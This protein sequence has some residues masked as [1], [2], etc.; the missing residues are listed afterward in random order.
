ME[1][2]AFMLFHTRPGMGEAEAFE[3]SFAYIDMAEVLGL[4]VVWLAEYHFNPSRSVLSCPPVTAA[5]IAGRTKRL[6]VGMAVRVLPLGNPLRIAE[7]I[8]TLDHVLKGRF[9]FGVGRSGFL[10]VYEGFNIPYEESRERLYEYLDVILK[11]WTN[12]RF[13]YRGKH[14]SCD[15]VCVV[16]KPYQSPHPRLRIATS[17]PETFAALGSKGIPIFA[18]LQSKGLG[19]GAEGVCMYRRAWDEAGHQGEPSVF[20]RVPVY[21][22]DTKEAALKEPEESMM[23]QLRRLGNQLIRSAY[24]EGGNPDYHSL[25]RGERLMGLPWERVAREQV[26]VD[27][28]HEIREALQLTG[29]VG[30]F[31]AGE[32]IPPDKVARSLRLFCE[33]VVPAFK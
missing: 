5:A 19:E 14:F 13:S 20:L 27:R 2:G 17:T 6:K 11:A 29:V 3:E 1:F 16:P 25:E 15:D 21:V 30:E 28:L 9:E 22:A 31:N 12:E 24:K 7:E 18:A 8:A 4:D 33:G 26:V 23:L 32:F 10:F